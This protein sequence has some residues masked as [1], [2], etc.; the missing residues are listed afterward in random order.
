[1]PEA[2]PSSETSGLSR[3]VV[4]LYAVATGLTLAMPL[5]LV[6]QVYG[7]LWTSGPDAWSGSP[8]SGA[9]VL[10]R[11]GVLRPLFLKLWWTRLLLITAANVAFAAWLFSVL[12]ILK[13]A[14]ARLRFAPHWAITGFLVPFLNFVRPY[15]VVADAWRGARSLRAGAGSVPI[16]GRIRLW[17]AF[18]LTNIIVVGLGGRASQP[19]FMELT[20]PALAALATTLMVLALSIGV[21][22]LVER[23]MRGGREAIDVPV[24]RQAGW[25]LPV[26]GGAGSVAIAGLLA[27]AVYAYT[28]WQVR[29]IAETGLMFF[30]Q[31][32]LSPPPPPPPAA[33]SVPEAQPVGGDA[34]YAVPQESPDR[35]TDGVPRGVP[36]GVPGGVVGGVIGGTPGPG[37]PASSAGAV[38]LSLSAASAQL[39]HSV[40]PVTKEGRM[41]GAAVI[42]EVTINKEGSVTSARPLSGLPDARAPAIDAVRQWRYR[43]FIVN[44]EP[45]EV[46][47][48]VN[49]NFGWDR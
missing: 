18:I 46:V 35:D 48:F 17:W 6:W 29:K 9:V 49:V 42:L 25:S 22:A 20:P 7:L 32:F 38:R 10:A 36:G 21:V 40:R 15:Q 11:V 23:E 28:A 26:L 19:G 3:A 41:Q 2:T 31:P 1:M 4:A 16:P 8:P 13:A 12:K 47:T 30:E 44:G 39:L 34:G 37:A 27:L 24:S 33:R 43:P 45:V 14:G 5:I